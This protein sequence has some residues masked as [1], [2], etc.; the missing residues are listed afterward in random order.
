MNKSLLLLILL[1]LVSGV[2]N[3]QLKVRKSYYPDGK[4]YSRESFVD[5]IYEGK[6]QWFYPSGNLKME[7]EFSQGKL[8]GW[9]RYYYETGIIKE[10]H[11]VADG[12]LDG[13]SN[14]Y[15]ENGGLKESRNYRDGILISRHLVEY[16]STYQVD[17]K[18]QSVV[19]KK[20][21]NKY[22]GEFL[23]DADICPEPVGGLKAIEEK[24]VYPEHAKLYGLEGD[25]LIVAKID[26]RGNV[27]DVKVAKGIG[28]GC[29]EEAKKAVMATKFIPAQKNGKVISSEVAFKVKFRLKDK[30]QFVSHSAPIKAKSAGEDLKKYLSVKIKKDS[31]INYNGEVKRNK[32]LTYISCDIDKCPEPKGGLEAI[33]QNLNYPLLAK[34][35][36][37]EGKVKIQAK[38]DEFG[39][40]LDTKVVEGIGYGCDEAAESAILKTEFIPGE[41]EGKNVPA[42]ILISVPFVLPENQK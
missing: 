15:Y 10:E 40:V 1:F 37:I 3:G 32:K 16:D 36:K 19:E 4:V 42:E 34:R 13:L 9:L 39:F 41:K 12:V 5:G 21:K 22:E 7:K 23:C 6:S 29:D 20:E 31:T 18:V 28:L 35:K 27:I 11:H 26:K 33:L 17:L 24:L 25:V 2:T 8:N 38:I 14:Y 30:P